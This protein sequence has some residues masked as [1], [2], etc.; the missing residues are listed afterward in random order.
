MEVINNLKSFF[1]KYRYLLIVLLV[2]FLTRVVYVFYLTN[3]RNYLG[4]DMGGYWARALTRYNGNIFSIHQWTAW[5]TFFH[6]YLAFVF[7]ILNFLHLFDYKLEIIL[8]L[9]IVY[10]T[11]AICFFYLTCINLTNNEHISLVATCFYGFCYPLIYL[12]S[13]VLAENLAIPILTLSLYFI[14]TFSGKPFLIFISG[15]LYATGVSARPAIGLIVVPFTLYI[16]FAD[17]FSSR[18]LLRSMSFIAGFLLVISL[19]VQENCYISKGALTRIAGYDGMQFFIA[20][21]KVHYLRSSY[22]GAVVDVGF[23]GFAGKPEFARVS[24]VTNHPMHDHKYF[25][26][27][28]LECMKENPNIWF[29]NLNFL[30]MLFLGPFF[31][32]APNAKGFR[33][34]T[35]LSRMLLIFM[36]SSFGLIFFLGK[37]R[38]NLMKEI[39][40]LLS[41]PLC[42]ALTSYFF[43]AE[44][45]YIFP[46]V[47]SIYLL[48]F[49]IVHNVR[50]FLKQ[51][52]DKIRNISSS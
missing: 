31:P 21:C 39:L 50:N 48:F 28:G 36:V 43:G 5:P 42:I 32:S 13:F 47:S 45:R 16:V 25:Y 2:T 6:F 46:A 17:R 19:V 44:H 8:L 34:L 11:V 40:L 29:E 37:I 9:N 33:L 26:K 7:K 12:N 4:S 3:Y 15:L 52:K 10:S 20:Q 22:K 49:V 30:R 51:A 1:K 27:L 41:V 14:I 38:K 18:S 24:F 35:N 23:P